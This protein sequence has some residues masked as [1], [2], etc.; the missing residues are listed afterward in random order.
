MVDFSILFTSVRDCLVGH[1]H[2]SRYFPRLLGLPLLS[3]R[4]VSSRCSVTATI[5]SLGWHPTAPP[6]HLAISPRSRPSV[7]LS[8]RIALPWWRMSTP[9]VLTNA[10]NA[11][12]LYSGPRTPIVLLL[13]SVT[14][15]FIVVITIIYFVVGVYGKGFPVDSSPCIYL[16]FLFRP[17]SLSLISYFAW[18]VCGWSRTRGTWV[19]RFFP[20]AGVD[21]TQG[22]GF[23]LYHS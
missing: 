8:R 18:L 19:D 10:S 9:W 21:K 22:M 16:I 7:T 14:L 13:L 1:A 17:F 20:G 6:S 5:H 4:K 23:F 11:A 3:P 15:G 2:G 12:S